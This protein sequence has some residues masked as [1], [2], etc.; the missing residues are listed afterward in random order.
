MNKLFIIGLPRTG[1]TSISIALLDYNFKVAHTA[2]TQ[3]AFQRADVLSDSPCFCDYKELDKLFPD[4]KFVY[5]DRALTDWI[6]SIQMLLKKMHSNL[7][8]KTGIFN[9]VLKRSFNEAFS[10]YIKDNDSKQFMLNESAFAEEH[11]SACYHSHKNQVLSYFADRKD[12]LVINL[13]D[14]N[15]L[16]QLLSFLNVSHDKEVQFPHT[17]IGKHVSGWREYKHPNKI[18]ALSAGEYQRKF[19]DYK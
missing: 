4:S 15:S 7:A 16:Q 9:P 5:L 13:S 1:T 6:P 2:Y 11:L 18:N 19:F 12:L 17:N 3:H 10:L 8:P 14:K